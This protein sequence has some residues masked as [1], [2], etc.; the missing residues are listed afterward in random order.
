[1][2]AASAYTNISENNL[3]RSM[4][5]VSLSVTLTYTCTETGEIIPLDDARILNAAAEYL[6]APTMNFSALTSS[7]EYDLVLAHRIF[8]N[9]M[10]QDNLINNLIAL[11]GEKGYVM[12]VLDFPYVIIEDKEAYMDFIRNICARLN[13]AGLAVVV[14]LYTNIAK[15]E[16]AVLFED[17]D[18][19]EIGRVANLVTL[20][21][22]ETGYRI[23][24]PEA[25]NPI[26]RLRSVL[27]Y[28]VSLIPRDKIFLGIPNFGFDWTLPYVPE[29]SEVRQITN[30]EAITLAAQR[31]TDILF[32][33]EALSP[34]FYYR[35]NRGIQHVVRFGDA[36]SIDVRA[37]LA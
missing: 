3:R 24:G 36:R 4:P 35:D 12:M 2:V 7:G 33:E 27:D 29:R 18:Y 5:Y 13:D 25:I 31:L 15:E 6:A 34:Y 23:G 20:V 8:T 21:A 14:R 22:F 37:R 28:W 19:I 10:L 30:A 17:E 26:N 9:A 16:V 32:D 11:M 1:M